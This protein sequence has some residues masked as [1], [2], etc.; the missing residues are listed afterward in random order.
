[1]ARL[2]GYSL[3]AAVIPLLPLKMER[4][5]RATR[6]PLSLNRASFEQSRMVAEI[7]EAELTISLL[8]QSFSFQTAND[9]DVF[10]LVSPGKR[11]DR[12]F[13]VGAPN[14]SSRSD[15]YCRRTCKP[16]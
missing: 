5:A 1:M 3:F 11:A 9:P 8:H 4:R 6:L 15:A 7:V 14:D 12:R 10:G 2:Q 13:L 16:V